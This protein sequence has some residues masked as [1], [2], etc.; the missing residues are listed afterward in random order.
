MNL[1]Q[2]LQVLGDR[3]QSHGTVNSVYGTPIATEGKTLIP[4]SRLAFGFGAGRG[5]SQSSLST[6]GQ[7][8]LGAGVGGG[9]IAQPVGMFEVTAHDTRFVS[10]NET[11]KLF[12]A[13]C[14][15]VGLGLWL[16]RRR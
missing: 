9:I 3:L 14:I 4:V 15:G 16:Q 11:Q 7:G 6:E 10:C 8:E 5:P 2:I 1:Q 12:A 13:L